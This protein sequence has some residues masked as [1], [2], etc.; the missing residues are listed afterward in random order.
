MTL[1][2]NLLRSES[3]QL[4]H[5]FRIP[6]ETQCRPVA[7]YNAGAPARPVKSLFGGWWRILA[8]FATAGGNRNL[9]Y[10]TKD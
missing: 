2:T 1:G 8:I 10:T 4:L 3:D 7:P 5:L 6:F 9:T